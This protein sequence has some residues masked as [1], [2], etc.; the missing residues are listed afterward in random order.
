[1]GWFKHTGGGSLTPITLGGRYNAN[2]GTLDPI[3][4]VQVSAVHEALTPLAPAITAATLNTRTQATIGWTAPDNTGRPPITGYNVYR[5]DDGGTTV[6]AGSVSAS[7]FTLVNSSLPTN[8][9]EII[10]KY[11]VRAVNGDGEGDVSNAVL[12]QWNGTPTPQPPTAPTGLTFTLLSPTSVR[13]NWAESFDPSVTKHGIFKG[14][15]LTVDDLSPSA[16]MYTWTGLATGVAQANVNVRRWNSQGWSPASNSVTFTP[17][18]GGVAHNISMGVSSSDEPHKYT[19][20]DAVRVYDFGE[21]NADFTSFA[22]KVLALT[23][24]NTG[25]TGS[26]YADATQAFLTSFYANPAHANVECHIAIGNEQDNKAGYTSG[27]TVPAGYVTAYQLLREVIWQTSGGNRV[28]PKASVWVDMTANQIRTGGSGPRFKAIAQYLDG[29]AASCYPAGRTIGPSNPLIEYFDQRNTYTYYM[30]PILDVLA[31]WRATGGPGGT[32]LADQLTGFACW[33]IGIPIHHS[34]DGKDL[35][36]YVRTG[37]DA[38]DITQRPRYFGG[39]VDAQGQNHLGFLQYV[40]NKLDAMGCPMRE[41]IYWDQQSNAQ[42]P[43]PFRADTGKTSPD[44]ADAWHA[45]TPGSR[46]PNA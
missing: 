28:F 42:I 26:A 44:T 24:K 1:M 35:A 46:L 36:N 40:Y 2:A 14:N 12:L 21:A 18:A 31:D 32:S 7:T 25:E 45:W 15:T 27:A 5:Q 10:F 39:G 16:V 38:T 20:W 11:T 19:Q 8:T 37:T 3:S 4:S 34:L 17:T 30:D 6:L 41:M 13:L 9:P 43:N 23:D 33:E 29:M 22:P